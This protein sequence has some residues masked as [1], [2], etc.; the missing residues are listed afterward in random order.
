MLCKYYLHIG[1]EKVDIHSSGCIDISSMVT[2]GDDVKTTYSRSDMSGVIRKCGSSV[3]VS[4]PARDTIV[5]YYNQNRMESVASFAVYGIE[6]DWTY[7][8]I[9]EC[10]VDFSSFEYDG[11]TAKLNFIDSTLAAR[12][13]ANKS[14]KYEIPVSEIKDSVQLDYDSV[15]LRRECGLMVVG[16]K[17]DDSTYQTVDLTTL[18]AWLILPVYISGESSNSRTF[19]CQDQQQNEIKYANYGASIPENTCTDSFF[20]ECV[21]DNDI[22]VSVSADTVVGFRNYYTCLYRI[23]QDGTMTEL[24]RTERPTYDWDRLSWSGRLVA[25]DR[26]Q[27]VVLDP[28]SD[29]LKEGYEIRFREITVDL[30]W[31]DRGDNIPIDVISPVTLLSRL[32][33]RMAGTAVPVTIKD[34]VLSDVTELAN[35]RLIHT[36]LCAAESIRGIAE[37]KIYTSFNDFCEWMKSVFGYIYVIEEK[38]QFDGSGSGVIG[39]FMDF[40]GFTTAV[41]HGGAE[42]AAYYPSFSTAEGAFLLPKNVAGV[43]ELRWYLSFDGSGNYQESIGNGYRVLTDRLYRDVSSYIL[44]SASVSEKNG[45]YYATLS[46]YMIPEVVSSDYDGIVTF[47]GIADF[48]YDSGTWDGLVDYG[49]VVFVRKSCRF[50]YRDKSS[51]LYYSAFSGSGSFNTAYGADSTHIYQS[52]NQSYVI[53]EDCIVK[54]KVRIEDNVSE[55]V[56]SLTFKHCNEVYSASRIVSVGSV[57]SCTYSVEQSR[58]YSSIE[59]G[60]EKQDYDLGNNG[61]DEFNFSNTY[62]TGITLT[63]NR[64]SL[65]SPYRADCY[66]IEELV[67]KRSDDTSSSSSDK[68]VFAVMCHEDSGKYAVDRKVLV[69]GSYSDT[70]FNAELSP[71]YM[72]EA[73]MRYLASFAGKLIFASSEGNSDIIIGGTP[74]SSDIELMNPLFGVGTIKFSTDYMIDTDEWNDIALQVM[75]GDTYITGAVSQIEFQS[76]KESSYECQLIE[77]M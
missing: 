40:I 22:S 41:N 75:I 67:G 65:M 44:Y 50:Y 25:G 6:N 16:T 70:V 15:M 35:E 24:C 3:S 18:T 54:C 9:F 76:S 58:I 5:S 77:L 61:R 48:A 4:G 13:K 27:L 33:E 28:E 32:V 55:R 8:K 74:V 63:D 71:I 23:G 52:G 31:H 66:G 43:S 46:E 59:I 36:R 69:E 45:G 20:V 68:S 29:N 42:E 47:G 7:S 64:L 73:N 21:E 12:I 10:P 49:S 2:N 34:T 57:S 38:R 72:V 39:K 1:S 26:L 19:I 62:S 11:K 56:T 60:Y 37:A 14:T 17:D 30:V 53:T 51:G